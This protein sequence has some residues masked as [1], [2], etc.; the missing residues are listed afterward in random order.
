[1]SLILLINLVKVPHVLKKDCHFND[2]REI[3]PSCFQDG[4]DVLNAE[5]GVVA[6]VSVR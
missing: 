3:G 5:A 4:A 6:N 2:F 1:M